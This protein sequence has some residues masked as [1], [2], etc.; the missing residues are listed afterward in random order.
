[1]RKCLSCQMYYPDDKN[2]CIKCGSYLLAA[3][4]NTVAQN[5]VAP[6]QKI[7][8]IVMVSAIVYLFAIFLPYVS[9]NFI[10]KV[11]KALIDSGD[12]IIF[13]ILGAL[14]LILSFFKL[15][16]PTLVFASLA[17]GMTVIEAMWTFHLSDYEYHELLNRE[18]GYYLLLASSIVFFV[19]SIIDV[20]R[21]YK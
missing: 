20:V 6:K 12:G 4:N 19:S 11:E 21:K 9:I 8:L 2:F 1:M 10:A 5:N 17:S 15:K 13:I 7:N 3:E 16:I 14:V 18:I